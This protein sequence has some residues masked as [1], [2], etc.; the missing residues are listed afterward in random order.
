M[1]NIR[2]ISRGFKYRLKSLVILLFIIIFPTII[3][4]SL[5]LNLN[6]NLNHGYDKRETVREPNIYISSNNPPNQKHFKFFK[7]ITIDHTKV[8]GTSSHINFPLLISIYDSDLRYEVQNDG[9]DIAFALND[10]W[11]DHEIELFNQTY[12]NTHAHLVAWVRIPSLSP[13]IDTQITMYYSN[14]T[15]SSRENPNGVWNANYKGVWHLSESSG[16]ARDSTF[17]ATHGTP[18]GGVTQGTS[19]Q[20]DGGYYCDGVDSKVDMGD[21]VDGHLDFGTGSFTVETWIYRD[22]TMTSDQYGAI[23]KGNGDVDNNEGWLMRFKGTNA[24]RFSGGDGINNVFNVYSSNAITVDT[25]IHFV[26]VLDRSAGRAYIYKDGQLIDSDTSITN[27]NINSARTLYLSEDWSTSYHFKGLFDEIRISN[28]AI[29]SEWIETGYNNQYNPN[30]FYSIG[31]SNLVYIPSFNDFKYYKEIII[32]HTKVMGL[33]DHTN[34]PVLISITDQDLHNDV[35]PDGQ[36]IAFALGNDWLDHEIELFNQNYNITHAQLIA[37]VRFPSLSTSTD[38]LIR[39]FYGNSTLHPQG[40]HEGVWNS[41]YKGVWHLSELSGDALD[42]TQYHASGTVTGTVSRVL[43][44]K[45]NGGFNFATTG[46]TGTVNV[47]DPNDNHLDFGLTSFTVSFWINIDDSLGTWQ[48]PLYKGASSAGDKGF[49]FETPTTGNYL[50]FRISD[51]TSVI[52][53]PSTNIIFDSWIHITGVVDRANNKIRIYKD[54]IEDGTGTDIS[55]VSGVSN[56][57]DLQFPWVTF[58]I[59]GLLDEIRISN[60]AL[61]PGWIETEYNNQH[62]PSLFFSLG[63]EQETELVGINTAQVN[64]IDLYGNTIPYANITMYNYTKLIR[65]DIADI[66]GGVLFSNL[67]EAEYNFTVTIISYDGNHKEIVNTTSTAILIDK[68]FQIINLICN[69]STNFFEVLDVDGIPVDS[70][71]IIVGNSSHNLQ[72]CTIDNV[73]HATFWWVNTTPYQY[74]YSI[75]YKDI[76]YTPN[77]IKLKTGVINTVNSTV[78]VQVELTTVNFTVITIDTSQPV[79]GVKLILNNTNTEE[80]IVNLTT[81]LYGNAIFRWLNS[82][83][84]NSNYSLNLDFYGKQWQFEIS[85]LTLG[86][87]Y[88][89]NFSINAKITYE[90]KIDITQSELEKFETSLVS[91]NPTDNIAI[92]WGSILKLRILFNVTKVPSSY[93]SFLGPTYADSMLYQILEGTTLI[94]SQIIPIEENNIG[95]HQVKIETSGL[96]CTYYLIKI[97]AQKSGYIL[98]QDLIFQLQILKNELILNQSENDY[99]AQ[100]VYWSDNV[101]FSV[102]T[103]GAISERFT[104]EKNL[105]KNNSDT[106]TFSIPSIYNDFNLSRI[107]FNVYNV[108]FGVPEGDINLN[109]TD[110]Y[111][112]KHIFNTSNSNYYYYDSIA[113]NGSWYNLEIAL[114]KGSLIGNNNFTFK[115]DGTF[116]ESIDIIVDAYFIR[117]TINIQFSEFNITDTISVLTEVEGWAIKRISFEIYNCYNTSTWSK[118]NLSNPTTINITTNEGFKYNLDQG[119]S[120]GTGILTIDDRIIYP[121][122]NQFLFDVES[123]TNVIFDVIIKVD[124]IQEFYKNQYLEILNLSRNKKDI[125]N[126]GVFQIS[127]VENGWF[128][129]GAILWIKGINNGTDYLLPSEINMRITIGGQL[130]SISDSP[131]GA[132]EGLFSLRDFSKDILYTAV[133]E[134][135]Q[136]VNFTLSFTIQYSRKISY[137]IIGKVSYEIQEAPYIYGTIEYNVNLGCYIKT[138][139]TS[140]INTGKY[141]LIF[142]PIKDYYD[143]SEANL[144]LDLIILNRLTLINGSSNIYLYHMDNIYVKDSINYTFSYADELTGRNII[145]LKYQDFTWEKYDDENK[146]IESGGGIL[147]TTTDD[148]YVLDLN[149]E[150]LAVG[151]YVITIFFDKDNYDY[152]IVIFSLFINKREISYSLSDRFKD[153]QISVVQGKLVPIEIEVTDPTKGDLPLL[154]ATVILDIKGILYEFEEIGNGIYK[155]NFPTDNINAFFSAQTLTGKINVSKQDYITQEFSITIVVQMEEVFPGMPTFYFLLILFAIAA[156]ICSIVG[157]RVYKYATIPKFVKKIR[158]MKKAI[159]GNKIIPESLLYHNKETFIGELIREKWDTLGLSLEDI[160]GIKIEKYK[161]IP[162]E[163]R[164]V[165]EFSRKHDKKPVG[166]VLMKWDERIGT[167]IVTTYPKNFEIS[168]KTLLQ[169][170]SAHEYSEEKGVITLTAGSLNILSYY[171]GPEP[172][173]Y[174]LLFLNLDDDPDVYEG[175]MSDIVHII[176]QNLPDDSYLHMIPSLFHRIAVYPS[177]SEEEILANNYYNELKRIIIKNLRDY[178]AAYKSE[179]EIWIK[180]KYVESYID[181]D[182]ILIDLIK[183][184]IIKEV[185]VKGMPSELIFLTKDLFM[186]RVPPINL[187]ENPIVKGLPTQ[188]AKAYSSEVKKFFQNYHPSEEDNL[189]IV[190]ILINPQVYETLRLLRTAIITK[191]DFEKLKKKGVEDIYS[192]L[193]MLWDTQMIKVF[194]DENNIEY[195]T[196]LSDLYIDY[197]FPKYLLSNI[198]LAYEQKSKAK[199]VLIEYLK[200]L[201]DAYFDLKTQEKGKK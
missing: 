129:D 37:W 114:N 105:V 64:A 81:D 138:I 195:Y 68:T 155:L 168:E 190:E 82:S 164:E 36:D 152:K 38:T 86:M 107:V 75:F 187:L 109:I 56:T 184:D 194:K 33:V 165:A 94:Q 20:I 6:R 14:S 28:I 62:D 90:I 104:I 22:G 18:S 150:T 158:S 188:F 19:G 161:K 154:N 97:S 87:V 79:S 166:M 76:D 183:R 130:Y 15:M 12:N 2:K 1:K 8:I 96:E 47:G 128:D 51:G 139:D 197:I 113:N 32:D 99:S 173:Y 193:K 133:I 102:N 50:S 163:E 98:P 93:E 151:K 100:T 143:S 55:G 25:W 39:M 7:E 46:S 83:G 122:S 191:Q 95:V 13:L 135:D 17:Y 80:N 111:G 159:D 112:G 24:V 137:D 157:Y 182:A 101:N 116:T 71:W 72:N 73:G 131:R 180:D 85:G 125:N 40:S 140:I 134:A 167:E 144:Y 185:S 52:G 172:G 29:S 70:G 181:L 136:S 153:S 41:N 199:K 4:T 5:F 16:L 110:D 27:G 11:L 132:G 175:G 142:S 177:L 201:E 30:S 120:N 145:G 118:V 108:T 35:Q 31:T 149:T 115:I 23:F 171:T 89:V 196:L 91:F 69:V 10:T 174:L 126:G 61:T 9:D 156:S 92:K 57:K 74:N 67:T 106:F 53:S 63:L 103:Y 127:A 58:G 147:N 21:P 170:Y 176:L 124:Y 60:V 77:T 65:T 54:G 48:V 78:L 186:L 66:N 162:K 119:Y 88:D 117:D 178:G 42:S 121:Q 179:L 189:R 200:V 169:V 192:V 26:G 45:V 141:T 59:D 49:D 146:V 3:N 34:F 43:G 148:L 160:F 44:G 123:D 84:I 198:K